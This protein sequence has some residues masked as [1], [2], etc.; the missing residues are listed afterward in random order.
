M[1]IS[2]KE[3]IEL[4]KEIDQKC[5]DFADFLNSGRYSMWG[6]SWIHPKKNKDKAGH[7]IFYTTKELLE[8]YKKENQL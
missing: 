3:L 8:I 1:T 7:W 2:A 6:K 4:T 5:I